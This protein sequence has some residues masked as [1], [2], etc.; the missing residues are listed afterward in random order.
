[1]VLVPPVPFA[2]MVKLGVL[3]EPLPELPLL[4]AFAV[5]VSELVLLPP[6]PPVPPAPP[7]EVVVM[8]G[9]AVWLPPVWLAVR[10]GLALMVKDGVE[11]LP[12]PEPGVKVWAW[13]CALVWL[14]LPPVR[15]LSP[16][17]ALPPVPPW[18][19]MVGVKFWS[20][21]LEVALPPPTAPVEI[22]MLGV[23]PEPDEEPPVKVLVVVGAK[24]VV[25]AKVVVGVRFCV[26]SPVVAV[27]PV[28]AE[29]V[30]PTEAPA[31]LLDA[32]MVIEGVEPE[33]PPEPVPRP[34]T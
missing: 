27:P 12:E 31:A 7:A 32:S 25:G 28:A 33:P 6:A 13:V 1:M 19:V 20:P 26:W 29:V 15:V 11:P 8:V 18:L 24:L 5:W 9:L 16:L 22:V 34:M 10:V 4:V 17:V 2:V 23:V 30:S 3:P 14:W 21:V